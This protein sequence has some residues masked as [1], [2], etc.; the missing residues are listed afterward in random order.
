[1]REGGFWFGKI[2]SKEFAVKLIRNISIC[3]WAISAFQIVLSF[4]VG[5]EPAVDGILYGILGFS[6]YWFKS[7]VAGAM[8]LIL[9]LT[10]VV[11]TGINWLTDNPGGTNII[12]ALFLL[13]IS[14][15]ATQATFKLHKLR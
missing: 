3:F 6:L 9:S 1:M 4:F 2:D 14:A 5:F 11:V 7:R 13:W 10:T 15:R 8:L 12:L